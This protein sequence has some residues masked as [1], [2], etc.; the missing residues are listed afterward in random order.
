MDSPCA[1]LPACVMNFA[2]SRKAYSLYPRATF[3]RRTSL[4]CESDDENKS[5]LAHEKY[6]RRGWNLRVQFPFKS[7]VTNYQ[8]PAYS[9]DRSRR[10]IG[11]KYCWTIPIIGSEESAGDDSTNPLVIDGWGWDLSDILSSNASR[12]IRDYAGGWRERE[13]FT[14]MKFRPNK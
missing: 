1:G 13:R 8:M 5:S 6:R 3:E 2:T 14:Y 7:M 10:E 4:I 12:D 9:G 11:D